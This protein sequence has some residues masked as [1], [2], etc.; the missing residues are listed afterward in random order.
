MIEVRFVALED[1]LMPA[2]AWRPLMGASTAAI[3]GEEGTAPTSKKKRASTPAAV[4][5][6]VP[7]LAG[8]S[9]ATGGRRAGER[10]G[11]SGGSGGRVT[12]D[13]MPAPPMP[14]ARKETWTEV[15]GRKAKNKK[16]K[17]GRD[18][19][20]KAAAVPSK[21]PTAVRPQGRKEG[22]QKT[23]GKKAKPPKIKVPKRA[24]VVLTAV[25]SGKNTVADALI[26]IRD[27]IELRSMGIASLR[28]RRA[29][30]GA[31]IYEI[32]GEGN[33]KK[34]DDF[35]AKL[36]EELDSG[37]VKVTRPTKMAELR[38]SGLDDMT[39]SQ[40]VAEAMAAVGGCAT[41][42]VQVGNIRRTRGG[43]GT[44]WVRCPAVAARKLAGAGRVQVGWVMARVEAL[45][46]R[47][48]QCFKCLRTGHTI[49]NC[50]SGSTGVNAATAAVERATSQVDVRK[51]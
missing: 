9:T 1:R 31:L 5:A 6:A 51:R 32:P 27:K 2:K 38:L 26:K 28:P 15:L 46:A 30:T 11:A 49:G 23:P 17:S 48:I 45:R 36:R 35:A 50:D 20:A 12:S 34:A 21:V 19:P 13:S 25:D 14:P 41:W 16:R 39:E 33:E 42:E 22:A 7:P 24:A 10:S 40:N 37:Q 47:P 29:I 4:S 18:N 3:G 8:I 43:L 44:V